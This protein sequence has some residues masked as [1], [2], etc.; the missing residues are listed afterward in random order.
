MSH[1]IRSPMNAILGFAQL[2]RREGSLVP[3]QREQVETILRSGEHLLAL[4]TDIL[5]YSRIDAGRITAEPG[6]FDLH[7]LLADLE[8]MFRLRA[9]E[10]GLQ[11]LFDRH[12]GLPR[13]VVTD[14]TRLRQ[15]LQN[16]LTN[17]V[18]FTE[19]GGVTLRAAV[20]PVP[21][22]RGALRLLVEVEDTGSGIAP[23]ELPLLFQV[24]EQT[25]SGRRSRSGTG[26]G[27]A[28]S[29][30]FAA[31]LGGSLEV[32]STPGSGSVFRLARPVQEGAAGVEGQA[33]S[34]RVAD[35]AHG[36]G[37]IRVLVA[38]DREDNRAFLEALLRAV[39]FSVRAVEDGAQAVAV[40]RDWAPQ[41]VLMD[42]RMPVLPGSEA[43]ARIRALPGGAEA[44]ILVVTASAFQ[45]DQRLALDAGADDF[46]SKPLREE[47]LFEKVGRLLGL[48]YRYGEEP[49]RDDAPAGRD[50]VS[51]DASTAALP[52]DLVA[53]LREATLGADLDRILELCDQAGAH[54]R[55]AADALRRLALGFAYKPLL[56]LLSSR[57]DEG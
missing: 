33:R 10:K 28:I 36:Q 6:S 29:Q 12:E 21:E 52:A 53:A 34:R 54:D 14:E 32:S 9:R 41:L 44:R 19:R 15:V 57:E 24:F 23:E 51:P 31:L 40:F 48:R 20:Q 16:L 37:E 45:E 13:W 43:I 39:G 46:L 1:E 50:G 38:D 17:A 3:R 8:A 18:K 27:L 5:E 42:L 4:I 47:R 35:L 30:R 49:V 55:A 2:L 56:A 11:L 25:E 26:L 7:A 22:E